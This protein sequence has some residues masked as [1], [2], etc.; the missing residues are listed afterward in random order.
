[1]MDIKDI[2]ILYVEIETKNKTVCIATPFSTMIL[3]LVEKIYFQNQ[4]SRIVSDA[5]KNA[6]GLGMALKQPHPFLFV[7][8]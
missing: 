2:Y 4:D 8:F 5:I 6:V 3:V 7:R 1:M